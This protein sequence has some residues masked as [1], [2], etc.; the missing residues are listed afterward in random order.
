MGGYLTA[1]SPMVSP[2]TNRIKVDSVKLVNRELP[3]IFPVQFF[4]T[5]EYL[6]VALS[7]MGH[8]LR[9]FWPLLVVLV[10]LSCG[11]GRKK[12]RKFGGGSVWGISVEDP[13]FPSFKV[14]PTCWEL[15]KPITAPLMQNGELTALKPHQVESSTV[16][17]SSQP[18]E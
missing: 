7:W 13:C 2:Y 10:T 18:A 1:P 8:F 6:R 5:F 3:S 11:A 9:F 12:I 15:R 14:Y 17:Q 4:F 16:V